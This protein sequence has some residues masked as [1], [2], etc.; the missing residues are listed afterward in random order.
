MAVSLSFS[1]SSRP[2]PLW[3]GRLGLWDFRPHA[4][5]EMRMDQRPVILNGENG[6]GKTSLLEAISFLAPG[7]G[8]RRAASREAARH[9]GEGGWTV[10]ADLHGAPQAPSPL[11]LGTA[12]PPD[13]SRRA[14]KTRIGGKS[15]SSPLAFGEILSLLW[16]T[17]SMDRLFA[18]GAKAR[19]RFLD[20]LAAALHPDHAA[21]AASYERAKRQRQRL[22]EARAPDKDWLDALE[23]RMAEEAALLAQTRAS[24]LDDLTRRMAFVRETGFPTARFSL[25]GDFEK[26]L[27]A[28]GG[29]AAL[30]LKERL[31]HQRR[32]DA[33]LRRASVGPHRARFSA[34][35]LPSGTPAALASS[36]EQKALLLGILLAAALLMG[37]RKKEAPLLLLDEALVHLDK[38]R[39]EALFRAMITLGL[40]VWM[41]GTDAEPFAFLGAKAQFFSVAPGA[42]RRVS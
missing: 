4:R 10:S 35:H 40:Q 29:Q 19:L 17:P 14:R 8:L 22:L 41:T 18:E 28:E 34:C 11:P 25:E 31:R 13:P 2:D 36:G 1:P 37:E 7:R 21:R 33:H 12:L 9:G 24:L 38:E 5:L 30:W 26:I 20:R 16:I 23:D 3:L 15:A 42:I 6:G 32:L 39:R 27:A